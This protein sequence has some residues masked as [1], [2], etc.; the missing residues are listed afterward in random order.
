MLAA[1]NESI[2]IAL[3]IFVSTVAFFATIIL[4]VF[5]V[6]KQFCYMPGT[7]YD[8]VDGIE[9]DCRDMD[10]FSGCAVAFD[11][12]SFEV[13]MAAENVG[14]LRADMRS[15]MPKRLYVWRI[16]PG[17]IKPGMPDSFERARKVNHE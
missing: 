17:Q 9:V 2:G 16:L 1:F 3:A 14:A 8:M 7:E 15:R 13:L 6:L 11:A 4:S 5:W 12:E 10:C